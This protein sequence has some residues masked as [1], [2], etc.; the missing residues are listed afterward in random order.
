LWNIDAPSSKAIGAPATQTAYRLSPV[1]GRVL[2][3]VDITPPTPAALGDFSPDTGRYYGLK[4]EPFSPTRATTIEVV[5][6]DTG[7]LS[8]LG[9]T[10]DDLHTLAFTKDVK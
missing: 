7:S 3:S 4:F 5:D 2:D 9:R 1:D 10:V 6:V 8:T